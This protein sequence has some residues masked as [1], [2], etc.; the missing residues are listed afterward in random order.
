MTE[1]G[2]IVAERFPALAGRLE[3]ARAEPGKLAFLAEKRQRCENWGELLTRWVEVLELKPDTAYALTGFGDGSHVAALLKAL[4]DRSAVFCAEPEVGRFLAAC[5][6]G[7][8]ARWVGD[9]RLFLGLGELDEAFFESLFAFPVLEVL[10]ARPLRFSPVA[11][12]DEGYYSRF[13]QEFARNLEYFRKLL[14]TNV[15]SAGRWQENTLANARRLVAAPDLSG[16]EGKFAGRSLIL[17]AAGPSLDESLEFVRRHAEDCVVV[18]VNSSYRA[19]RRAGIVPHFALAADPLQW[20]DRGFEGVET[21]GTV[22]LCP[23]IVYPAVPQRFGR[24]ICT[25]S[26]NSVLATHLRRAVGLGPGSGVLEHGTVSACVFDVA[27]VFGCRR[28]LFVGQDMAARADGQSHAA[29]SFYSDLRANQVALKRC[30]WLPGNTL[31]EVPVE[32]KLFVYLK[33]FQALGRR[34]ARNFELWNTSRLGARIEG[35]PYVSLEEAERRLAEEGGPCPSVEQIW[36]ETQGS[37]FGA[38]GEEEALRRLRGELGRLADFLEKTVCLALDLIWP[39]GRREDGQAECP[40]AEESAGNARQALATHL[41]SRADF[42]AILED[43]AMKYE[44]LQYRRGRASGR[45]ADG[46]GDNSAQYGW[47]VA[48]GGF[49]LLSDVRAALG[50]AAQGLG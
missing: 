22:L 18:A 13:F 44:M 28:I 11:R 43:G 1:A 40:R 36:R 7:D 29:D 24:R 47:A 39:S 27:R 31:P 41:E 50:A 42:R 46:G 48:E 9:G 8:L 14:G 15:V 35:V 12:A 6:E 30:R 17:A 34:H 21:D 10:D 19:L 38:A 37:L 25:W 2:E 49:K 23:F 45:Q 33:T 32:E 26:E 5:E 3:R 20:V 16:W 4:P